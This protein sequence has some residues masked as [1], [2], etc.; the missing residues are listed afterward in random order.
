MLYNS[1]EDISKKIEDVKIKLRGIAKEENITYEKGKVLIYKGVPALGLIF[2][3]IAFIILLICRTINS[4]TGLFFCG[5]FFLLG[6]IT[7]N[8]YKIYLVLDYEN[9]IIYKD[10]RDRNDKS[11]SKE[12]LLKQNELL[13]VGVNNHIGQGTRHNPGNIITNEV[14]ESNVVLLKSNGELLALNDF[15]SRQYPN[16]CLLTD[17]ISILFD[18]P[19]VKSNK[20]QQLKVVKT[21]NGYKLITEP[22]K[23]DSLAINVFKQALAPILFFVLFFLFLFIL[24]LLR[25]GQK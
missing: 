7:L 15:C 25:I 8:K 4:I 18:V 6:C 19:A 14:E 13:S 12:I 22:L 21:D 23:R 11:L 10:K 24:A 1:E 2:F 16:D 5:F 20:E 3:F 17:A 9:K